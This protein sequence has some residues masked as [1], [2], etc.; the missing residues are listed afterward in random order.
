MPVDKAETREDSIARILE[1]MEGEV[2]AGAEVVAG[3]TH[4]LVPEEA[5]ALGETLQARFECREMYT[6]VLGPTAGAHFGPGAIAV[7]FYPLR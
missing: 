5:S 1:L 7:G 2:G 4:A 3:I 6:F